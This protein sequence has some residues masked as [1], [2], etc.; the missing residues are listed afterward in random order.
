MT[1]IL[2]TERLVLRQLVPDDLDFVALMLADAQVMRHYPRRYTREESAEWI[3]R[4]LTRYA[5][6][7]HGLWLALDRAAGVPV[8]QVGLCMQCVDGAWIP[9]I[10]YLLHHRYWGKGY[11]TEGAIAVRDWAFTRG[12]RDYSQVISLI[13]RANAPSRR[14][15]QRVGMIFWRETMHAGLE[16]DVYRTVRADSEVG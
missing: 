7:G 1:E 4:Q 14:V 8:G 16:H 6:D 13:R 12:A 5:R 9:E 3:E 10:G 15:A 2:E 11:A